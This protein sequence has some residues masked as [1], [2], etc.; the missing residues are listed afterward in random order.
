[1]QTRWLRLGLFQL[2]RPTIKYQPG[3]ANIVVDTLSRSQRPT[4][5]DSN[6]AEEATAQ[7]DVLLLSGS[8]AEPQ[9]EDLQKWKKAYQEDPKLRVVLQKLRQCQ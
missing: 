3:K 2:I 5:K 7:E 6:Q 4:A 1:M 9:V 8:L